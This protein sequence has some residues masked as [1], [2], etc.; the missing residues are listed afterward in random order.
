MGNKP[1]FVQIKYIYDRKKAQI[2]HRKYKGLATACFI[3]GGY[4]LLMSFIFFMAE[5]TAASIILL[6]AGIAILAGGV[7]CIST[8]NKNDKLNS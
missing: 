3:V 5:T 6:L 8:Y 4:I 1:S 2:K 7:K